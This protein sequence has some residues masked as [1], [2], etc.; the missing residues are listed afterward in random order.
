MSLRRPY[1]ACDDRGLH[2]GRTISWLN[3]RPPPDKPLRHPLNAPGDFY[4]EDGCCL[5]CDVPVETAPELFAYADGHCHVKK[6]PSTPAEL[7]RM[8]RTLREQ[9]IGCIRFAGEEPAL[10]RRIVEAGQG[11]DCDEPLP[12]QAAF[13]PRDSVT[14]RVE[15]GPKGLEALC[16]DF[17]AWLRSGESELRKYH[18]EPPK[19]DGPFSVVMRFGWVKA[20]DHTL[21]WSRIG[22][23]TVALQYLEGTY[24]YVPNV[25]GFLYDWLASRSFATDV[26]WYTRDRREEGEDLPW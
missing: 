2:E 3:F 12:K 4:V 5:S 13:R 16:A 10:L 6:Q 24:C 17:T 25:I 7:F 20:P 26:R 11:H 21:R 8:I 15:R 1:R 9:E 22:F 18:V 19:A 14:F 23:R